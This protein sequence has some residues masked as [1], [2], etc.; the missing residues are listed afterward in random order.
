[1]LQFQAQT[2]ENSNTQSGKGHKTAKNSRPMSLLQKSAFITGEGA[3]ATKTP[4]IVAQPP[5]AVMVFWTFA[6]GA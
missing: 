3:G 4:M 6:R 1:V 2:R 5:P